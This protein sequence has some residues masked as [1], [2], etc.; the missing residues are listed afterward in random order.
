MLQNGLIRAWETPELTSLNKLPARATF[1]HFPTAKQA[2]ARQRERSPWFMSLDGEWQF[3]F[4]PN[5]EEAMR[6]VESS[7]TGE[8]AWSRILVPGN[9]ETQGYGRPHYTNHQMP[10]PE[11]PPHVPAENPTGVY[12]RRFAL[13][14]GW[15]GRRV[16]IHFGGADSVLAVYVN[17]TAV[18]LSKDSR[19]PAEF[20]IT[21]V[22]R[23]GDDNEVVAVVVKWSD[24]TFVEDQ[25]MWWLSGLHR[26]VFVY[27][28]PQT[29]LADIHARAHVAG[30]L[31][32]GELELDV[33]IGYGAG[34][35]D[36]G[37]VEAQ[38]F[39]PRGRAVFREPLQRRV[40]MRRDRDAFDRGMAKL[41]AIVPASRLALWSHETPALYTLLVTLRSPHGASHAAVRLGFR[42]VEIRARDLLINGRRVLFKGV[43]HHDHHPDHGKAVPFATMV[44]DVRLMKQFNFNAVRCSHYPNDPRWLELCDEYGL[45]VIDEANLESHAFH[46]QLCFNSRYAAAWLD[47]TMRMVLRDKNH[48]AVILWS[49]GNE[50]G[51]GPNQDAAA[52]WVRHADPTRPVI[53]EGATSGQSR[54]TFAHGAAASDVICPMYT[55][56]EQ[57]VKWSDLVTDELARWPK[58]PPQGAA[59]LALGEEHLDD[60]RPLKYPRPAIPTPV[61]PLMR[62]LILC[63]Y[64]HAMGNSCGSLADYFAVFRTKP[65]IQGG[66]IW[67]WMDHAIRKKLPDG[68]EQ[69]SYGGD[70]GDVPNDA[71]FVC[72]GLVSADREPYP[73]MWEFKHLAQPVA[74]ALVRTSGVT[75]TIA[76]RNEHD[77]SSLA[78]LRGTWELTLDGAPWRRGKLSRLKLPAGAT[79]AVAIAHGVLPAAGEAHLNVRFHT[80][81]ATAFAPAGHEVAWQQLMLRKPSRPPRRPRAPG[82]VGA[83]EDSAGIEL[84]GGDVTLRFDRATARLTSLRRGDTELLARGLLLQLWRA[85]TDNDGLKLWKPQPWK[86]LHRWRVLRLD[87]PLQHRAEGFQL[88]R[89]HDGSAT[90]TLVH[91][92]SARERWGD[93]RHTQ[94]YTLHPDGRVAVENDVRLAPGFVDLPRVGVRFDLAAGFEHVR[95]FGRGPWD[96]YSDRRASAIAGIYESSVADIYVP[97][98]MPQEHGHRTSVRWLELAGRGLKLRLTGDPTFGCNVSHF[99]AEDLFA[100]KHTTDLTARAETIIHLDAAHRGLGTASC[101]PDTLPQYRL[102]RTRHRLG[103]EIEL[104]D[105]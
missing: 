80:A 17:G 23:A 50:S 73:A 93:A 51:Y 47:R 55:S 98:V 31:R 12:R 77:F 82:S 53:Y 81:R 59:L 32:T 26:E 79:A 20:D 101:G 84:R 5:P 28:T 61:H 76:V 85:A 21:A 52:G 62:P 33:P 97:Y 45:Y 37:V 13:P 16:V 38:L 87:Q 99:T 83:R 86:A 70:F 78:H 44:R 72:D 104:S 57:L 102:N 69:M 8:T 74:V 95:Y 54:L 89:H 64:S 88:A 7:A 35:H 30:D 94:R 56:L 105:G 6:R 65:G 48:P 66:F 10:W 63:E 58:N 103:Y 18:G 27:A 71:N 75:T 34:P 3:R 92:C 9:W 24:A 46:N 96:N 1:A 14:A 90:V 22:A 68:R 2:V 100:A 91:A 39:D 67:E 42:R 15:G 49:L 25:D 4:E 36:E 19:L 41:R 29:Y 11:E 40:S 43:N 60:N